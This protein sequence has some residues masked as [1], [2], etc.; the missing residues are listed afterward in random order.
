MSLDLLATPARRR[1]LFALL[2]VTEG[3][4]IGYLWTALP[5]KLRDA[6]LPV[7]E[8]TAL[9]SIITIPWTLKFLWAPAVDALRSRRFGLR[10]WIVGAQAAMALSLLPLAREDLATDLERL[11]PLLV[12]HGVCAATQDVSIDALAVKHVPP[13]ERG[14]ATG[15]MQLGMVAGRAAFGGGALWIEQRV[16][17]ETVVH[18]LVACLA[19]SAGLALLARDRA[20]ARSGEAGLG[21]RAAAVGRGLARVLRRATTWLGLAFAAL[22]GAAMEGTAALAGPLLLDRGLA[23][24]E[25]GRFFAVPAIAA[26]SVGL[27]AGGRLA[28]RLPRVRA[29][30]FAVVALAAAVAATAAAAEAARAGA[31]GPLLACLAVDYVLFGLLTAASY[32]LL[33]DLTDPALGGTQ[34]SAYMGAVNFCYVWSAWSAGALAGRFDYGPALALLAGASLLALPL[35]PRLRRHALRLERL[36]AGGPAA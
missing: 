10:P 11:L 33:M 22:A 17:A 14:R 3:A 27:W 12:L 21:A 4:P 34:F 13:G 31:T 26:M 29:V 35:L 6:G 30:A 18:A 5:T 20:P 23:A 24:E 15:W 25:V 19:V 28:D 32:A 7:A 36:D 1:V 8:V 9:A 16:G 2:Y